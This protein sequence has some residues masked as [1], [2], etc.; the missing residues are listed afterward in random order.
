MSKAESKA[1][2]S[3]EDGET[4]TRNPKRRE[5]EIKAQDLREEI[6]AKT[7]VEVIKIHRD[8]NDKSHKKM[9]EVT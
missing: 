4:K 9:A 8:G 7:N 1:Q 5:I 6:E 2:S 3:S